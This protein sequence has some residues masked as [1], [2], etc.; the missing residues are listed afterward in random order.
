MSAVR[1]PSARSAEETGFGWIPGPKTVIYTLASIIIGLL[2]SIWHDTKTDINDLKTKSDTLNN[3]VIRLEEGQS[4]I[5]K[6]LEKLTSY[7]V[8]IKKDTKASLIELKELASK[9]KKL[10]RQQTR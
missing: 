3:S 1:N 6:D 7:S 5:K 10:P 2:I 4:F 8:D 9:D